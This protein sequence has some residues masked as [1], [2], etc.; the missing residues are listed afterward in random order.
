MP[1]LATV[2]FPELEYTNEAIFDFP[3][4]LPGFED[5]I[6][7]LFIEQPQTRPLVFMQSLINPGLCFLTLPVLTVDPDYRL[8]LAAEDLTA[9]GMSPGSTPL[10]GSDVG[11][12]V[13]MTVSEDSAPTVNMMSPIVINLRARKG[14][15]SVPATSQYSLRHPL[16]LEKESAPCS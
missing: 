15:Q 4:G 12:F 1:K 3:S 9:L 7:F 10:I 14:V 2:Y 8:N 16:V 6:A 5:Q 11:C 13:L